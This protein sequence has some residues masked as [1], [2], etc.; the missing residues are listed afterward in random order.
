M[1]AAR[2]LVAR[3]ERRDQVDEDAGGLDHVPGRLL[4]PVVEPD[5]S[6]QDLKAWHRPRSRWGGSAPGASSRLYARPLTPPLHCR[7][8]DGA[9]DGSTGGRL[10]ARRRISTGPTPLRDGVSTRPRHAVTAASAPAAAVPV[11][12]S[13][14]SG[15]AL[16]GGRRRRP[17]RRPTAPARR[18]V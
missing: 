13:R 14:G 7:P 15:R 2:D 10:A 12:D 16:G 18:G 1:D 11:S 4:E 5:L 6:R 9:P 8:R 17:A 3:A